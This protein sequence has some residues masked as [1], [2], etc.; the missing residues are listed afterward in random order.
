MITFVHVNFLVYVAME[1]E[2]YFHI[3]FVLYMKCIK[4]QDIFARAFFYIISVK[5][6]SLLFYDFL[7]APGEVR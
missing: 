4:K 7:L 5:K 2:N 1:T 3:L 6:K